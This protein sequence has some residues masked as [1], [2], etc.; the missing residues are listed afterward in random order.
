MQ[1]SLSIRIHVDTAKSLKFQFEKY[2]LLI[3]SVL[4]P[5]DVLGIR[6]I[7]FVD[8]YKSG[9]KSDNEALG[10]YLRDQSGKSGI[11]EISVINL[12]R[13]KIPEYLFNHYPEI[14]TLFLSEIL[15]HE[16]GHHVHT[17]RRHGIKKHNR[18]TFADAYAKS[19]YYHYLRYRLSK[20]LLSYRL[21]SINIIKF[22]KKARR[23]FASSRRELMA[24]L[25]KN[26]IGVP[27]P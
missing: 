24:W 21:A 18:E 9:S 15:A 7:R 6:E 4:P 8:Q 22:D 10:S 16:I 25:K 13:T 26:E 17:F 12:L 3:L 19:G 1:E 5:E 2:C 11:I 23:S 27:F 14:A 20:I